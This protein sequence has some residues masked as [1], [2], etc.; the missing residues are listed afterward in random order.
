MAMTLETATELN[1]SANNPTFSHVGTAPE[2]VVVTIIKNN[3]TSTTL[4]SSV[5]Y[6][7]AQLLK[8]AV[9]VDSAGEP[10]TAEV[11]AATS[12]GGALPTGS[13]TVSIGKVSTAS[14]HYACLSYNGSTGNITVFST[15]RGTENANS[16]VVE[17]ATLKGGELGIAV[18]CAF[19]GVGSTTESTAAA[20][21]TNVFRQDFGA[22]CAFVGRETTPSSASFTFGWRQTADD[23]ALVALVL[24]EEAG[25][26]GGG[27]ALLQP[28][29]FGLMGCQ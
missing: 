17:V 10:G 24:R 27:A 16:S 25:G 2:A 7:V 23:W 28:F 14:M 26:G 12:T 19:S 5:S 20:G 21:M 29:S 3:G 6:G 22:Q 13:Q 9:A 4:I 18:G 1:S 15:V 11:W 8:R